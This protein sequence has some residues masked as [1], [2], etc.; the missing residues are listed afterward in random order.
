MEITCPRCESTFLSDDKALREHHYRV[1]CSVCH[2]I[3]HVDVAA[4][5]ARAG[6]SLGRR[7]G[8]FLLIL[9]IILLVIALIGQILWWTRS[10]SYA[11]T[12]API[13]RFL[14]S[15]AEQLDITIPWP[16]PNKDI[17]ILNSQVT[18]VA[19]HLARITGN[20]ENVANQVQAY[21]VIEVTLSNVYGA[22]IA[23]LHFTA[24]Q[25]LSA[26]FPARA[27]FVPGTP[28][29]FVLSSPA[30]TRAAGYQIT[31]LSRP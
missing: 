27:G 3:F 17:R 4:E 15:S 10:Y 25:Y 16:G 14:L 11:A 30:L 18:P 7:L 26:E 9:A 20:I 21:P 24:T 2:H 8:R 12:S 19:D 13:R 6:S 23:H 28:V 29:P 31:L 5:T 1:K 22:P